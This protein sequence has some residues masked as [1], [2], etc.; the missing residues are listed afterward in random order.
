VLGVDGAHSGFGVAQP[1][2]G[3][4]REDAVD[5]GEIIRGQSHFKSAD[6][7]LEAAN[8]RGAGDGE[9]VVP[10]RVALGKQPGE[11]QLRGF[12]AFS[13]CQCFDQL[14]EV[15]IAL[16]VFALKAGVVAAPVAG[17]EVVDGVEPAGE[18][19]AAQRAVG[20]KGDAQFAGDG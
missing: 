10:M 20:H 2:G 4:R 17:V 19:A 14:Y 12:A 6:V 7:F 3:V 13:R 9:Y 18:E 11:R 5:L 8:F 16:E 15:Q 1:G